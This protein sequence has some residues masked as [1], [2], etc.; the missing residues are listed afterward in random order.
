MA[1]NLNH[2]LGI[3]V[4][5][6]NNKYWASSYSRFLN[7]NETKI[8]TSFHEKK[9]NSAIFILK[10]DEEFYMYCLI[11]SLIVYNSYIMYKKYR[12]IGPWKNGKIVI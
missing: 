5:K 12:I 8:T 7:D 1:V 2:L 10:E 9:K 6:L 11:I 4:Y 3:K